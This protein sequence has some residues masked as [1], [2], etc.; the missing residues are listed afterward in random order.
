MSVKPFTVLVVDDNEFV[1]AALARHL[2]EEGYEVLVATDGAA[3][4]DAVGKRL[5]SLVLLDVAMP[6]M[7]GLEVLGQIRQLY[8]PTA[9]PVIVASASRESEEVLQAFELGASDYVTKPF[10]VPVVLARVQSQL[11]SR[12]PDRARALFD[13]IVEVQ[14]FGEVHPGALVDGR[15]RLESAIGEGQHGAVY[16][17]THLKL[18]RLVAIKLLRTR[19]LA[20]QDLIDRF[21]REG[22]SACRVEHP[23][24]VAVL[25]FSVTK[26]GVSFLVMELLQGYSLDVEIRQKGPLP[27]PRVAKILLPVCEVLMAAH[28]TGVI[29]R[30]IK[31]QNVF[32]HRNRRGKEV[33]KVLDFGIAKLVDEAAQHTITQDGHGPGTPAYMA[34]ERFADQ[35]YDGRADV[36]SVGIM[37]YLM[38]TGKLPFHTTGNPIKLAIMHLNERVRP[39]SQL[40]PEISD[41]LEDV[42]LR[43]LE[44]DPLCRPTAEELGRRLAAATSQHWNPRVRPAK[45]PEKPAAD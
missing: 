29:H 37:L 4:L 8:P 24:A 25:D 1:R 15:Y 21:E 36:Y 14:P 27:P 17:A 31:P 38:L 16:R 42:V 44:K 11:R 5:V 18:H 2:G 7:G 6:G 45:V 3:A 30:D 19:A 35:K 40:R 23:N 22:I 34:P 10:D 41:E 26:S 33:V 39:P 12:F 13:G 43:A 32:L 28:A 20:S 9:L